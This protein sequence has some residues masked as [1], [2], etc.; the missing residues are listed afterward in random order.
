[1]QVR[2]LGPPA[3]LDVPDRQHVRSQ[4]V[5]FLVHLI[6]QGGSAYQQEI[7]D[8]LMP[9]PPRRLAAQRLHTYTYNLRRI[10]TLIGGENTYRIA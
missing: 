3:I 1:M 8:D 7:L 10:C 5:E 2:V 9:E 6:V 4:A